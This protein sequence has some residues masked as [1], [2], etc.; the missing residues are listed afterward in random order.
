MFPW[1]TEEMV[2]AF[3]KVKNEEEIIYNLKLK[4]YTSN[5]IR[6]L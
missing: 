2:N 1:K 4:S 5:S 6:I 3:E